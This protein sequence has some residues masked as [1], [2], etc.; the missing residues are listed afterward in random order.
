MII[1]LSFSPSLPD[2][3]GVNIRSHCNAEWV[4]AAHSIHLPHQLIH[5]LLGSRQ[6]LYIKMNVSPLCCS[7]IK[8]IYKDFKYRCPCLCALRN[9]RGSLS[10]R[11]CAWV[12]LSVCARARSC[13][14]LSWLIVGGELNG[15]TM[16]SIF[17][18]LAEAG[19]E[20]KESSFLPLASVVRWWCKTSFPTSQP[21]CPPV[22][23]GASHPWN[24]IKS[25]T[26]LK[27]LGC[28]NLLGC[29]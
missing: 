2:W 5:S 25:I 15:Q 14:L 22:I 16:C 28:K 11:T 18:L 26:L 3:H 4:R 24:W 12:F 8:K 1:S 9:S 17:P 27:S 29:K 20:D 21:T 13:V 23:Q 19:C 7:L 10:E 6:L